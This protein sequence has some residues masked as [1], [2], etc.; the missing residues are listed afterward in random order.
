MNANQIQNQTPLGKKAATP[1]E[2][3]TKTSRVGEETSSETEI[4][5]NAK[6]VFKYTR[7]EAIADG[8][9]VDVSETATEAGISWPVALTSTVWADCVA[10]EE[11]DNETKGVFQD[12]EGRLWDVLWLA[13]LALLNARKKEKNIDEP[14]FFSVYRVPREG[15]RIKPHP[16]TLKLC[17]T[18]DVSGSPVITIMQPNED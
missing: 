17:I 14:V 18:P 5:Y 11:T 6:F 3:T 13:R 16:V 2:A 10:W 7:A 4:I 9:L 12:Q 15:A 8:V 1:L